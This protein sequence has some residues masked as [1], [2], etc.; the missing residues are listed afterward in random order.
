LAAD[1]L[2]KTA[3]AQ[4]SSLVELFQ[5]GKAEFRIAAYDS[6]LKTF[7]KLDELSLKEGLERERVRLAP[8]ISFYRAANLAALGRKD[9]AQMKFE[10]YLS[11][12]PRADLDPNAF[13]KA[14]VEAFEKARENVNIGH[15]PARAVGRD[16]GIRASYAR[17]Q[18][19]TGYWT[20]SDERWANGPIR[21]LMTRSEK[22][23][24]DRIQDPAARAAFIVKFWQARDPD[25]LT[26][27]NE[28]RE[29]FEKRVSFADVY[30]T[31]EEKKGSE[32]DRGLVFALLGPP[33]YI[34]QF[35][36]TSADDPIQAAQMEPVRRWLPAMPQNPP[37]SA[38]YQERTSVTTQQTQGMREIWHYG[39]DDLPGS[40]PFKEIEFEFLTKPGYGIAVLQR[41]QPILLA[42][43]AAAKGGQNHR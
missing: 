13:P 38:I 11:D 5:K 32:T 39:R 12:F 15:L 18:P 28:F 6:S 4:T 21:Y 9:D 30:F 25:T 43:E 7:E 41:D 1:I 16:E 29:E 42:L 19:A 23:E 14:V 35:S 24:W 3:A 2:P 33:T 17:F 26:P 10:E 27:E 36:L 37:P 20:A 34:A 31:I 40:V 8:A 22:A